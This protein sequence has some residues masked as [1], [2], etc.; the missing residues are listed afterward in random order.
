MTS[1]DT[2]SA[3]IP[4]GNPMQH[5]SARIPSPHWTVF[6]LEPF[7]GGCHLVTSL[8]V[9][10]ELTTWGTFGILALLHP[11]AALYPCLG[12]LGYSDFFFG[13]TLSSWDLTSKLIYVLFGGGAHSRDVYSAPVLADN[14][15]LLENFTWSFPH[16]LRGHVAWI[17][18]HREDRGNTFSTVNSSRIPLPREPLVCS[19]TVCVGKS[20]QTRL[21][22][23][24]QV[25]TL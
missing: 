10:W 5:C 23:F 14:C 24:Q 7:K 25:M 8:P 12:I 16:A 2:P 18:P 15:G 19:N 11:T 22:T 3:S 21:D 13:C 6:G 20:H 17:F 1:C 4:G 9:H